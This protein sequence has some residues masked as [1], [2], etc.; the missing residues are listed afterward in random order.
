MESGAGWSRMGSLFLAAVVGGGAA[1]ALGAVLESEDG[2]GTT[3]KFAQFMKVEQV[4]WAKVLK[5]A[6][7]KAEI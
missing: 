4:K 2:G 5:E 7:V 3:E 6:N 1:V